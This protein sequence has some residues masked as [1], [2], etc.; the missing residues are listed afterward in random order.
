M[1][2]L[3]ELMND[4]FY[5]NISVVELT[6][7]Y[8]FRIHLIAPDIPSNVSKNDLLA[9]LAYM[10][11]RGDKVSFIEQKGFLPTPQNWVWLKI[12]EREFLVYLENR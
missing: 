11:M 2:Q 1:I 6:G 10:K 9:S 8:Q 4:L 12:T 5:K 3:P 7:A